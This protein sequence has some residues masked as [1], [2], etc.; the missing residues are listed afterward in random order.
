MSFFFSFFGH[1][2][3]CSAP[4]PKSLFYTYS[5]Y[6]PAQCTL[7]ISLLSKVMQNGIHPAAV[8]MLRMEG[9]NWPVLRKENIELR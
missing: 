4:K 8:V 9:G 6:H 2:T 3:V 5:P 7:D 1:K